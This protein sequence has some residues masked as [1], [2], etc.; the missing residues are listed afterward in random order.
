[1]ILKIDHLAFCTT[2]MEQA[3]KAFETLGYDV[4]FAETGLRDLDN[5]KDL[6]RHFS[7]TLDMTFMTRRGSIS[8]E[9][10]DHGHATVGDSYILPVFE[11]VVVDVKKLEDSFAA[12]NRVLS[13]VKS[14]LLKAE[15]FVPE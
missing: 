1:M 14:D 11:C 6:M 13:R 10:L 4:H 15:F 3:I 8:I 2:Q 7:G 12:S 5:K 9:L